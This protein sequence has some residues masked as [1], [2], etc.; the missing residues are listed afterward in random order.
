MKS[1]G[2]TAILC[3]C[4]TRLLHVRPIHNLQVFVNKIINDVFERTNNDVNE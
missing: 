2:L 1:V 4:K 3:G